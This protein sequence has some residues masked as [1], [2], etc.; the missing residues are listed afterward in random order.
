MQ[1]GINIGR[2]RSL[3][4]LVALLSIDDVWQTVVGPG[5]G[6]CNTDVRAQY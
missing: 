6:S 5:G 1:T 3:A 2:Y 4:H